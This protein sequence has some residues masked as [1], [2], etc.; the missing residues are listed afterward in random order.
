MVDWR[1]CHA[2]YLGDGAIG[3]GGFSGGGMLRRSLVPFLL[4]SVL[5]LPA[6]DRT[7]SD[8][9]DARQDLAAL[10]GDP[11]SMQASPHTLQGLLHA[12]VHRVYAEQ[13]PAAARGLVADLR[14]VQDQAG[15]A[16]AGGDRETATMRL[17]AL[18]AA[19]IDVVLRVF[20]DGVVPRIISAVAIDVARLQRTVEEAEAAGRQMERGRE[21]LATAATMLEGASGALQAGSAAEG[22]DAASRAAANAELVRQE[23]AD[24]RRIPALADLFDLA[25]AAL[26]ADRGAD[27]LAAEMARHRILADAAADAVRSGDRARAQRALD[28]VRAEQIRVVLEVL[29]ADAVEHLNAAVTRGVAEAD[30]ALQ[31]ATSAG[32]DV[33]R[34][35]RMVATARD[36]GGRARAAADSGDTPAALDLASHAAGLVN[37]ARLAL[38]LR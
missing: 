4:F 14:R 3:I 31:A 32:R 17:R 35:E 23:V 21:L 7:P 19:E 11:A 8:P 1:C 27:G 25:A 36:M 15:R 28:A 5:A 30:V 34:L 38:T 12:A 6:C 29:G 2:F 13:G 33:S 24:A 16:M 22:L 18:H 10:L 37:S 9:L 26:Q 20:G